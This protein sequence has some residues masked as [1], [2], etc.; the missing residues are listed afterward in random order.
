MVLVDNPRSWLEYFRF[1]FL[2]LENLPSRLFLSWFWIV[3]S[4]SSLDEVKIFSQLVDVLCLRAH[5]VLDCSLALFLSHWYLLKWR[6][7]QL[8]QIV[9]VSQSWWLLLLPR[10]C[11][12]IEL[13]LD[14]WGYI[15]ANLGALALRKIRIFE[16]I[17]FGCLDYW[18]TRV[19]LL[20]ASLWSTSWNV[21]QVIDREP[22]C[23]CRPIQALGLL[24]L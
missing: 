5:R 8:V 17:I 12:A 10:T 3:V 4:L 15:R 7:R 6:R 2:P 9:P 1:N 13:C 11:H 23:L 21:P 20:Y 18:V 14:S 22:F 19:A 16:F 24:V